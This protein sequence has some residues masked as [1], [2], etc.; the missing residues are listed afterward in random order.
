MNLITSISFVW[1]ND[2]KNIKLAKLQHKFI[3]QHAELKLSTTQEASKTDDKL[4]ADREV[5]RCTASVI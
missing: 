1:H 5:F 2:D 3:G 4:M